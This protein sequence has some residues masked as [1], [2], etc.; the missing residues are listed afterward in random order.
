[1]ISMH[2]VEMNVI[3]WE[4]AILA[5]EYYILWTSDSKR[6]VLERHSVYEQID[7]FGIEK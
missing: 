2:P 5:I 7:I 4:N 1:M 3:L 6:T